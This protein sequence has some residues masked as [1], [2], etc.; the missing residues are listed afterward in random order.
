M[1]PTANRTPIW[2][3]AW[4]LK[5]NENYQNEFEL[6]YHIITNSILFKAPMKSKQEFCGF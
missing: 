6:I 4:K 2:Y 3:V 1:A 5:S